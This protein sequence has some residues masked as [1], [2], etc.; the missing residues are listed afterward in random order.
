M[1]EKIG[2]IYCQL[3]GHFHESTHIV[4][5]AIQ[6][7]ADLFIIHSNAILISV[8][9]NKPCCNN[10]VT[11]CHWNTS[12]GDSCTF[13]LC[14]TKKTTCWCRTSSSSSSSSSSDSVSSGSSA[15]SKIYVMITFL[16]TNSHSISHP[17]L[18]PTG[19]TH[20]SH[21]THIRCRFSNTSIASVDTY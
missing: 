2:I 17:I 10:C 11:S 12:T 9:S 13:I 15:T 7:L 8:E 20:T 4:I 1:R 14:T 5:L 19:W 6:S 16:L 18:N 3:D 21:W